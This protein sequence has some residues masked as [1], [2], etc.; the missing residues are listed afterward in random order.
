MSTEGWKSI[1]AKSSWKHFKSDYVNMVSVCFWNPFK[2]IIDYRDTSTSLFRSHDR[3]TS[4]ENTN[5]PEAMKKLG[6]RLCSRPD[7]AHTHI[8][9]FS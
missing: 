6:A 2:T 8:M 3:R 7:E 4:A 9:V 1:A 5:K